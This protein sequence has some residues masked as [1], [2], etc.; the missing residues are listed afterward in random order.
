M[1]NGPIPLLLI[2][3]LLTQGAIA[4]VLLLRLGAVRIPMITRGEVRIRDMA[5]SRDVWPERARQLSN[6]FDNQF[7]LPVLFYVAGILALLF[8]PTVFELLLA[9]GFVLSRVVH[10]V[11]HATD[12]HVIRRFFAYLVGLTI[13]GLLWLDIVVRLVLHALGGAS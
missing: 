9:W 3:A 2:A 11:I 5:L 8:G 4:F 13:L 1:L 7:Q 12:N 6:A 10:A